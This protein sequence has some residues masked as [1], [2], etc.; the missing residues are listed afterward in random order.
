MDPSERGLS[1]DP[2]GRESKTPCWRALGLSRA[3]AWRP[4]AEVRIGPDRWAG[5][6]RVL[7]PRGKLGPCRGS[8]SCPS[9]YETDE[10]AARGLTQAHSERIVVRLCRGLFFESV[11]SCLSLS[12]TDPRVPSVCRPN[13]VRKAGFDPV[14]RCPPVARAGGGAAGTAG[15]LST[16]R[17]SSSSRFDLLRLCSQI[18]TTT[19]T[20]S[21]APTT[22]ATVS[23]APSMWPLYP[24][25]TAV[26]FL[27]IGEG[28]L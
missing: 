17:Q 23:R 14:S 12:L 24:P 16:A 6:P 4:G 26:L 22:S 19:V 3:V 10:R 8:N 11:G 1:G 2:P 13:C 20:E 9:L 18:E 15:R 28:R 5:A 7:R 27:R 25:R 21:G